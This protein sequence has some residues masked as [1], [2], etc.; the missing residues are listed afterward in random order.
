MSDK[1]SKNAKYSI[2][3]VMGSAVQS[4]R[5]VTKVTK[6]SKLRALV[7]EPGATP[8]VVIPLEVYREM[9][10]VASRQRNDKLLVEVMR[11][12][13]SHKVSPDAATFAAFAAGLLNCGDARG[14]ARVIRALDPESFQLDRSIYELAQR[15]Y[16]SL[17]SRNDGESQSFEST[18]PNLSSMFSGQED[19]SVLSGQEDHA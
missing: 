12:M 15:T 11:T 14:A 16:Q 17:A 4:L 13:V 7:R 6:K 10:D 1:P 19:H 8:T 3:G 9:L 2:G 18:F 5:L